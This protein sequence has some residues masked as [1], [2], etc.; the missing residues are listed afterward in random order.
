[1]K[2][3]NGFSLVELMVTLTVATI[4]MS[5]TLPNL[6]SLYEA[7]RANSSIRVIQQTLQYGRNAAISY[8]VRVTVCPVK[9][10]QCDSDW[11]NGLTVF[12]DTGDKNQLDGN[13]AVLL[14]T[15]SFNSK[16][17]VSYNRSAVRFQPDGLASGTNGTLRYCPGSASSPYSK[18]VIVNQAGRVRFSKMKN[19]NCSKWFTY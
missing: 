7:Q 13:D 11:R 3:H 19:I 17:I 15:A 10:N 8:G 14:Q 12:T 5:I 16:D 6:S 4:L 9:D 1:M 2:Y 18:A